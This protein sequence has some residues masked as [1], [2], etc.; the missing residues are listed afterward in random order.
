MCGNGGKVLR[1]RWRE[2][3]GMGFEGEKVSEVGND[4][5]FF[6]SVGS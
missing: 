2:G 1:G 6:I 3:D 5:V 4:D